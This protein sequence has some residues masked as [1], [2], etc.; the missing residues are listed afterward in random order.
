MEDEDR[1]TRITLRLPKDLHQLLAD[2]ASDTSKSLNAEIVGRLQA[3]FAGLGNAPGGGR[4]PDDLLDAFLLASALRA[5]KGIYELRLDIAQ[6]TNRQVTGLEEMA[7]RLTAINGEI[8]RCE[9]LIQRFR[10]QV[11]SNEVSRKPQRR[12]RGAR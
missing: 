8:A 10:E 4:A 11:E 1:Y 5:E 2:A 12:P 7:Q 3:T 6:S 9:L